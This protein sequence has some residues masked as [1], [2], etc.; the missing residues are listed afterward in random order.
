M[1]AYRVRKQFGWD[2]WTFAPKSPDGGCKCDCDT[3]PRSK[4]TGQVG[5]GCVC[6]T[7][8]CHCPC[9]VQPEVYAGDVWLVPAGH[10]RKDHMLAQRF[11]TY[12]A[13]LPSVQELES[14][15]EL[16]QT[17]RIR[18]TKQPRRRAVA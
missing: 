11:A 1:E 6:G 15:E 3:V 5:S 8:S 4:C 7:N 10:P 17:T 14:N 9:G 2:G 16:M 13:G 18:A 12:D